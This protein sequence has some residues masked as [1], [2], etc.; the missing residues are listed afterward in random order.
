M[1]GFLD[2]LE[3]RLLP[4]IDWIYALLPRPLP[5]PDQLR[6]CRLVSHRGEHDNLEIFENTLAAF[7]AA[8]ERGVWGVEFDIRWTRDLEPVVIHDRDLRR[9][10]KLPLV[11]SE[12]TLAGL[13][14]ACPHV[15]TLAEMIGRYG[16]KVHLMVE[17]KQE[18]YPE[19]QRQ[20]RILGELFSALQPGRDFH[21]LGLSPAVFRLTTFAAPVAFLPVARL[22]VL[23]FSRLALGRGFAGVAGHY[24]LLGSAA[25]RRH[26][27]AGQKVGTG[28]IGSQNALFREIGRGVDW[29]FS[30]RAGAMQGLVRRAQF[31][32]S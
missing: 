20:N 4:M 7:D 26:H 2:R 17:V 30:N 6:S 15:P 18:P 25:I 24:A 16:G 27:S 28:Y 22:N 13:R 3:N 5:S 32:A 23:Q 1:K 14:Q 9:V 29:I 11:I 31:S 8:V 10:F 12:Y 21:L 19:P